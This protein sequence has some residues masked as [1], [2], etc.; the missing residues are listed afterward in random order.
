MNTPETPDWEQRMRAWENI[1][2]RTTSE[3]TGIVKH[4][5]VYRGVI[6]MRCEA[7]DGSTFTTDNEHATIIRKL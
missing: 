7:P 2:V 1:E 5:Y 4:A 6:V 3:R